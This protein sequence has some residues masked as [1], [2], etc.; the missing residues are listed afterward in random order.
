MNIG[1]IGKSRN[2]GIMLV[3]V[4]AVLFP[5]A[6]KMFDG[7]DYL[8]FVA[9]LV[10]LYTIAVSGLDISYG[11]CGQ[12][13]LGHAGFF[14]IGAYGSALIHAYSGIPVVFSMILSAILAAAVG[15]LIA[16]PASK[17]VFHFLSLATI[18]FT[19]VIYMLIS[20]SPGN[21]TNNF[22]GLRPP[23]VNLFGYALS[24]YTSMYFFGLVCVI[25]FMLFKS[26]LIRSKFGRAFVAIRENTHAANG[27]GINVRLYKCIAFA[28]GV[29]FTGYAGSMYAHMVN[30]IT[31]ETFMFEQSVIFITMLLFGGCATTAGPFIGVILIKL[32]NES[33]R[34]AQ[35]YTTFLYGVFLLVVIMFMPKG[36]LYV[37]QNLYRKVI[38][39][40]KGVKLDAEG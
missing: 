11:Y 9:C 19:E 34:F 20:Q 7:S 18:A 29:F 38:N 14:A 32:F 37:I 28:T 5:F 1:K 31:P 22:V 3:I 26:N 36:L 27:M 15:F 17:L 24:D 2:I 25:I 33:F 16:W 4:L 21:I 35:E 10:L 40:V 23:S 6:A 39:K 8:M 13:S 30:F 12:I